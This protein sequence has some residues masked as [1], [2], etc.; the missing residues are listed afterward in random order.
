LK[1]QTSRNRKGKVFITFVGFRNSGNNPRILQRVFKDNVCSL[2]V[3]F[4]RY[5]TVSGAKMSK[6]IKQNELAYVSNTKGITFVIKS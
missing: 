4:N 3:R 2:K 5:Q 6:I 1:K